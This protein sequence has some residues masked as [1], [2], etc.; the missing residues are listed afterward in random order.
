M[1]SNKI[2][3][4]IADD[5]PITRA[6]IR[7]FLE[8]ADDIDV[9]AEASNGEEAIRLVKEHKPQVLLL[10]M[11]MPGRKGVEVAREILAIG[12]PVKILAL[13]T[14]DDKQYIF[15]LL[16]AGAAGY[17]IKEEVPQTIVEAV[18]GVSRG[19]TG[20]ISRRVAAVITAWTTNDPSERSD[21]SERELEVLRQLV[22][23]KTNQDIGVEMGISQKT[24]EKH[25]ESIYSKLRVASRVEA[26]VLAIKEG[27]VKS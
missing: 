2:Q 17:L 23:G 22:K 20:W 8:R 1:I 24:V 3:V 19:E 16:S 9:V 27:L 11:E 12:L 26:A 7:K 4:L 13:S 6:G 10:D 5:H 25:L 14:Y 21:L 18:R 15:G